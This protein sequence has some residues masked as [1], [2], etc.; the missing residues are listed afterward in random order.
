LWSDRI[1]RQE[2]GKADDLELSEGT[3]L[4]T[5]WRVERTPPGSASGA[6]THRGSLGTRENRHLLAE[7]TGTGEPV[8]KKA[9]RRRVISS[10][11]KATRTKVGERKVSGIERN[12]KRTET[13]K[14]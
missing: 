4:E 13:E 14:R 3:V 6:C 11:R 7:D 5:P 9:R 1:T 12:A 8:Y 2:L 10:S